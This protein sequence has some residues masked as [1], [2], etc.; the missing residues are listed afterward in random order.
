MNHQRS[1]AA[2]VIPGHQD[3]WVE[4]FTRWPEDQLL[5]NLALGRLGC[6]AM[7]IQIVIRKWQ[8]DMPQIPR[9][10]PQNWEGANLVST[11]SS[12]DKS[13]SQQKRQFQDSPG[14][15]SVMQNDVWCEVGEGDSPTNLRCS[16][17]VSHAG[18]SPVPV[19]PSRTRRQQNMM[20]F[21]S[22]HA[23]CMVSHATTLVSSFVVWFFLKPWSSLKFN[24]EL[25]VEPLQPKQVTCK[26][27]WFFL[28]IHDFC[29]NSSKSSSLCSEST[30]IHLG[31]YL[32]NHSFRL[33]GRLGN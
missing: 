25:S 4:L 5:K 11:F 10:R 6:D 18:P 17:S 31:E 16:D 3:V 1:H 12:T 33:L 24:M 9:L 21:S 19:Q 23:G 32:E 15:K 30:P 14:V 20:R 28:E 13:F 8:G 27:I 29:A 7:R 22:E 2:Q 26:R